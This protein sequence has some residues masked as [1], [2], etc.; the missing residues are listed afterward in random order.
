MGNSGLREYMPELERL[1]RS[2]D[3]IIA[4]HAAWGLARLRAA[5]SEQQQ[6]EAVAAQ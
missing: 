4:E 1:A 2:E 3:P 5:R 6:E